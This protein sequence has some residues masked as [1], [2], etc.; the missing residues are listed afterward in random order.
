MTPDTPRR[1]TAHHANCVGCG[2]ENPGSLGL[3]FHVVGERVHADVTFDRRH[4]GAP[5]FVHGGSIA[6]AIDDTLGTLLVIIRRPAVT[7]KLEVNYRRPAFL[8][9]PYALETWIEDIDGRKLHLAGELRD[10]D[11]VVAESKALF[12]EVDLAHF[13][14][15]GDALSQRVKDFWSES[16]PELPY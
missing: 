14:D 11:D 10:G 16:Q 5:G 6:T 15:G 8:D 2:S 9:R 4:E 12:V 3:T 7:A 1:L 13:A